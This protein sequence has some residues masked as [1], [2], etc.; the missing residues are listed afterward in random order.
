MT[1]KPSPYVG[2]ELEELSYAL[3]GWAEVL[4]LIGYAPEHA[5]VASIAK[6]LQTI[7]RTVRRGERIAAD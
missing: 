7:S 3:E 2:N 1:P 5:T 4:Q 6:T